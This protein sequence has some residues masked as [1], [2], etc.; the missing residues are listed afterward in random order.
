MDLPGKEGPSTSQDTAP[1]IYQVK[2]SRYSGVKCSN[3]L[4]Q[5]LGPEPET[6]TVSTGVVLRL[7][8]G[9]AASSQADVLP[10]L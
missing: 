2:V 6:D 8:R 10:A 9:Y 3:N 7:Q 4:G 5:S 1:V